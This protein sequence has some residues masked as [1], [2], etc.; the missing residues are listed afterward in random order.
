MP[1]ITERR[2]GCHRVE[3]NLHT[4][5]QR[6]PLPPR[7]WAG[8]DLHRPRPWKQTTK[9][10]FCG[11]EAARTPE[12]ALTR[13]HV[14]SKWTRRF[15]PRTLKIFRSLRATAHPDRTDFVFVKRPGDVRDWQVLCVCKACN[16]GWMRQQIDDRV[17]PIMIPLMKGQQVRLSPD[18]QRII[19]TWA[20]MK[21]MVA[22]YGELEVVT[23]HHAHRKYLMKHYLPPKTGWSVW[24]THYRQEHPPMLWFA[25]PFL[26]LPDHIVARRRDRRATYYNGHASTQIIGELLIHVIRSSHPRL[27]TMFRFHLPHRQAIFRI[28]PPTVYG[29]AWPAGTIDDASATYIANAVKGFMM[30]NGRR[31]PPESRI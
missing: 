23:T 21:A 1:R 4:M 13:E 3:R 10:I 25:S 2:G 31:S 9:C 26:V 8:L 17:R 24:I 27:A 30:R 28:W 16:N 12:G 15:V 5:K 7:R 29:L 18:Q 19:A 6:V 14:Y 22:E 20:T 11:V